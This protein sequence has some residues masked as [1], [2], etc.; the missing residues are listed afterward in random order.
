MINGIKILKKAY[1]LPK[2]LPQRNNTWWIL[3]EY[4]MVLA[5]LT[6]KIHISTT[7]QNNKATKTKNYDRAETRKRIK[8]YKP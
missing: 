7:K 4:K 1:Q 8:P 2:S 6:Q 5:T 3:S